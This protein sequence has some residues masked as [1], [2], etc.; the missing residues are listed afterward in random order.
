MSPLFTGS[1]QEKP[2]LPLKQQLGGPGALRSC[3]SSPKE[4]SVFDHLEC[5]DTAFG[6]IHSSSASELTHVSL[7][8]SLQE[9]YSRRDNLSMTNTLP[10]GEQRQEFGLISSKIRNHDSPFYT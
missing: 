7:H 8:I 4:L 3:C 6:W 10:L 2:D 5:F 9:V 1:P